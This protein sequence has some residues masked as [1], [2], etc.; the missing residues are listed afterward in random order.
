MAQKALTP[1]A[2]R[3]V[4]PG[5]GGC[6]L[7]FGMH[8]TGSTSIQKSLHRAGD[9]GTR[10]HY[11]DLGTASGSGRISTAFMDDPWRYHANQRRGLGEAEV[12]ALRAEIRSRL[13]AE[14]VAAGEKM[15]ILSAEALW[16]FTEDELTSLVRALEGMTS[17]VR[18]IGYIRPPYGFMAGRFQQRL[19]SRLDRLDLNAL[20][21][22]YRRLDVLDR[23]LGRD[24]VSMWKFDPTGF[25]EGDVVRDFCARLG[26]EISEDQ[27]VRDN[28]SLS[29]PATSILF[30]YRRFGSGPRSPR[31]RHGVGSSAMGENQ[32][33]IGALKDV[34][35]PKLR[36]G[37]ALV[38]PVLAANAEDLAWIEERLG[39]ELRDPPG[40]GVASVGSEEELLEIDPPALQAFLEAF[41]R[42]QQVELPA[43]ITARIDTDPHAVA[44]VV[45]ACRQA[46]RDQ[47]RRER[48]GAR[49]GRRPT[50]GRTR[51]D[52]DLVVASVEAGNQWTRVG[53]DAL[54]L[55]P[56]GAADPPVVVRF[57]P[58]RGAGQKRLA[59]VARVRATRDGAAPVVLRLAL[60]G[61]GKRNDRVLG[62]IELA[63][64]AMLD[65]AVPVPSGKAA[66]G[67]RLSC[68][69]ASGAITNRRARVRISRP[70]LRAM[71]PSPKEANVATAT[72]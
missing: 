46:L 16:R 42:Q 1:L 18:A 4:E 43:A 47:S 68:A 13:A 11:I 39:E 54:L 28:P 61:A 51:A 41:Q 71:A 21:P 48:R 33:V 29:R 20:Y 53:D 34:P 17:S 59:F 27:I 24:R 44:D 23:V 62:E 64:G 38:G 55:S 19:R 57:K 7:H 35:G 69:L 67:L 12:L 63:G 22:D 65:W 6:L 50:A 66:R 49:S 15:S 40:S 2:A 10:H 32:A 31:Q 14:V 36:F 8:K 30:A 25:P 60:E 37:D 5:R 52:V 70:I 56:N 58:A 3:E 45:Q 9:L 72:S 26:L